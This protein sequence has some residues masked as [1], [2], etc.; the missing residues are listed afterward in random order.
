MA[1]HAQEVWWRPGGRN[2]FALDPDKPALQQIGGNIAAVGFIVGGPV[3]GL[4]TIRQYPPL[5]M[6]TTLY[7]V[8]LASIAALF[9]ASFALIPERMMPRGLPLPQRL[10]A[11]AGWGLCGALMLLGLGGLANGYGTALF[12]RDAPAVAKH[13]TLERDPA[14]RTHYVS[15]RAWPGSRKVVDLGAPLEV[16]AQLALPI[17]PVRT[18]NA[19]LQAM[20]DAATIR[21]TL[22]KGRLGADWLK[23]IA[24]PER[25]GLGPTNP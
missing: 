1:S 13:E 21:L 9:L 2:P 4:V 18:P 16:Y 14:R 8:G 25:G 3:L 7:T 24:L 6:D 20:P 5:V 12:T 19:A 11:R 10:A 23:T 17:T 15:I 22:G